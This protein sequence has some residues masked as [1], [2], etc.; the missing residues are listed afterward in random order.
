MLTVLDRPEDARL[1]R[2]HEIFLNGETVSRA[3]AA[4]AVDPVPL[5]DLIEAGLFEIVGDDVRATVRMATIGGLILA[6]DV[7][8]AWGDENFVTGLSVPGGRSHMRPS[9][10]TSRTA[11]DV[12]TGSGIQALLAAQHAERVVGTDVNPHA[13]WLAELGQQLSGIDNT[14]WIEGA[15]FEPAR[16]ERF[17]LVVVNPP[18]TISPDQRPPFARQR[19]GGRGSVA[20]DGERRRGSPLR[21]RLCHGPVQLDPSSGRM[22]DGPSRVGGRSSAAMPSSSTSPARTRSPTR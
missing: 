1:A 12:G 10:A 4:Q 5:G 20:P 2:L 14:T 8:R 15:W 16:G 11:L 21:R 19:D 9:A 7:P 6:G 3:R 22:G 17:D 18:V 13:L